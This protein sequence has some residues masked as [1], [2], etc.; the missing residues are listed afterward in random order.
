MPNLLIKFHHLSSSFVLQYS[1]MIRLNDA[2]LGNFLQ[3]F[4]MIK[5]ITSSIIFTLDSPYYS[6]ILF[7]LCLLLQLTCYDFDP[8]KSNWVDFDPQ[9]W[10]FQPTLKCFRLIIEKRSAFVSLG[11]IVEIKITI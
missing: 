8:Q 3:N 9:L 5:L 11:L 1:K 6:S 10:F 2:F 7:Q 4:Q